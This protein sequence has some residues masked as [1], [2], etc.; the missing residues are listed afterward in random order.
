MSRAALK[1]GSR[2]RCRSECNVLSDEI[3]ECVMPHVLSSPFARIRRLVRLVHSEL[4]PLW[5][6]PEPQCEKHS[7]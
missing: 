5:Q 7:T 2:A 1:N 3:V 6:Q 4:K